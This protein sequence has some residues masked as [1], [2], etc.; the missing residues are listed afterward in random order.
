MYNIHPQKNDIFWSVF[1]A[2][3]KNVFEKYQN[4]HDEKILQSF[5]L[6]LKLIGQ[7]IEY[8]GGKF[9]QN[10]PKL[11]EVISMILNERMLPESTSQT[12]TQIVIVILLSKNLKLTQEQAS[13]LT[14]KMLSNS[15]KGVFIYFVENIIDYSSFEAMILPIF[16]RFCVQN[17][18]KPEYFHVLVKIILR[19]APLCR[20]GI[21]LQEWMRYP[22]D[23]KEHTAVV[24]DILN[25]YLA[26]QNLD[27]IETI[28]AY[29]CS[30]ICLPHIMF[31]PNEDLSNIL[32]KKIMDL[33]QML[34]ESVEKGL[35]PEIKKIFFLLN[36]SV[37]SFIHLFDRTKLSKLFLDNILTTILP[38][39]RNYCYIDS[40]KTISL[41]I[42]AL[43]DCSDI[44]T[45]DLLRRIN[46]DLENNFS[47]P[48]HEVSKYVFKYLN[49]LS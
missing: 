28:D 14:R 16:L 36:L 48:F 22:I 49:F 26:V 27:H 46:V 19:K 30:I 2:Q 17:E 44:V 45:I 6:L 35:E 38:L 33:L 42:S 4:N 24:I 29:L 9:L 37:E 39:A 13:L 41:C 8:K 10:P 11:I 23:F 21:K 1:I 12:I 47:S 15:H 31:K 18:L 40:L 34:K 25:K 20:S 5:E 3:L 7:G 43:Q 32:E